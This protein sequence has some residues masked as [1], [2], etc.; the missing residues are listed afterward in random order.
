MRIPRLTVSSAL[1]LVEQTVLVVNQVQDFQGVLVVQ[2]VLVVLQA[3][4]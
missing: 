3:E 1:V 2:E 4:E